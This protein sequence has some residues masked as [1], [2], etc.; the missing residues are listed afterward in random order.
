MENGW[1]QRGASGT[2]FDF[3]SCSLVGREIQNSSCHYLPLH[4]CTKVFTMNPFWPQLS[5]VIAMED[6]SNVY[7]IAPME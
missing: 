3:V 2:L 1:I 4:I 5:I 6:I 7:A